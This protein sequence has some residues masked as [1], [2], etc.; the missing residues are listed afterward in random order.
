MV[1]GLGGKRLSQVSLPW[2][3]IDSSEGEEPTTWQEENEG[4]WHL[5]APAGQWDME[6]SSH[7]PAESGDDAEA[8]NLAAPMH[9]LPHDVEEEEAYP[10]RGSSESGGWTIAILCMGLGL[11]AACV[12]IPQADSNRRL[13]YQREQ[14]RLD[15]AQVQKQIALN[16]EFLAKMESDPQLTER[17][18]Q[19]EMHAVEQGESVVTVNDGDS[20]T[21]DA[22]TGESAQAARMSPFSLV[23]VPPPPML[24]P[25][26]PVG[27]T[28]AA[29]C[30]DPQ[31]HVYLLGGGMIMV[32]GGL[33]L[34]GGRM[35]SAAD[36]LPSALAS[37]ET[38]TKDEAPNDIS[39]ES[40]PPSVTSPNQ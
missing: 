8:D 18:A 34:G 20:S 5:D 10:P 29:L 16:K 36:Q 27:G 22:S 17:L 13:V 24:Q 38:P 35:S 33:V 4:Q 40:S 21:G 19:R 2:S 12:I 9:T 15:L 1:L 31:W 26:Q 28:L 6:K 3:S 25:Y 37:K 14:L 23:K 30:R 32:A 11:I 7:L 39:P